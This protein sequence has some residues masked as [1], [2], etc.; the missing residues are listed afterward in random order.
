MA[1]KLKL[2]PLP[3]APQVNPR[4]VDLS[5]AHSGDV[6]LLVTEA[7]VV[8]LADMMKLVRNPHLHVTLAAEVVAEE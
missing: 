5:A 1:K 4:V 7:R 2:D 3:D 6:V 8:P